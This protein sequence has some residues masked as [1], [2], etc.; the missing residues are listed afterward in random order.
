MAFWKWWTVFVLTVIGIIILDGKADL[1][2]YL[3]VIDVTYLSFIILTTFTCCTLLIGYYNYCV[4]FK[5]I[6][7]Y[8]DTKFNL[9]WFTSEAM[10]GLGMIGTLI[11]FYIVLS[12][13][14]AELDTSSADQMKK[15]IASVA[16]GMG[17]AIIT[18]LTGLCCSLATKL[19]L[20][21]LESENEKI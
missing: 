10:L 15:T 21:L 19:Q 1:P 14:F 3:F 4:Q 2:H 5:P 13:G 12:T 20:V 6:D 9:L 16:S 18:T 11:G 8:P 17:I 7:R